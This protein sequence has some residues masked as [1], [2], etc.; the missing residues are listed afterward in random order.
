MSDMSSRNLT[1]MRELSEQADM[2]KNLSNSLQQQ[3]EK[4]TTG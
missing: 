1:A 3:I 2:L 4:Y